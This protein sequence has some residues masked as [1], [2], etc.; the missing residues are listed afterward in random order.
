VKTPNNGSGKTLGRVEGFRYL[1]HADAARSTK[2][3]AD[4]LIA[5]QMAGSQLVIHHT[6]HPTADPI[7]VFHQQSPTHT[8]S[9]IAA[10]GTFR[11]D[12][13]RGG[14]TAAAADKVDGQSGRR[15]SIPSLTLP[16]RVAESTSGDQG[17]PGAGGELSTSDGSQ[18]GRCA[19]SRSR[20]F[21]SR[22]SPPL[23]QPP[24]PRWSWGPEGQRARPRPITFCDRHL[25]QAFPRGQE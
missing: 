12:L 3:R 24:Q 8:S 21:G 15:V 5:D 7:T 6:A 16:P 25:D 9:Q 22:S 13:R 14:V 11:T 4:R 19:C 18:S 10:I 1:E 23:S 20:R 2:R 17:Q